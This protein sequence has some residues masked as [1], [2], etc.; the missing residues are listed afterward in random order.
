M[1]KDEIEDMREECVYELNFDIKKVGRLFDFALRHAQERP[2]LKPVDL[3][4]LIESG[5]DCEFDDTPVAPGDWYI[6]KLKQIDNDE[7]H[8]VSGSSFH[9]CRP[10]MNHVHVWQGGSCPLP[11]GLRV[12]AYLRDGTAINRCST[13]V[14]WGH[15]AIYHS[16]N[17][18]AFEVLGLADNYCWPREV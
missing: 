14:A 16:T 4:V 13:K 2:K 1:Y 7:Y 17:V 8:L 6:G 3:S 5:V 10:R 18:I 15:G 11:E 12:R 9:L